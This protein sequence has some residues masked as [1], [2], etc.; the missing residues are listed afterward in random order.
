MSREV[1]QQ[2]LKNTQSETIA[3]DLANGVYTVALSSEEGIQSK[4]IIFN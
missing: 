3:L 4:K 2:T 1:Y